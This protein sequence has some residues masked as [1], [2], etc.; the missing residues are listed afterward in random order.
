[1]TNLL[2][3]SDSKKFSAIAVLSFLGLLASGYLSLH[4]YQIRSGTAAFQSACNMGSNMNCDVVAASPFSE[5]FF[6][7][8]LS[9]FAAGWF[10]ALIGIALI[11]RNVFWSREA[12]RAAVVFTG[13]GLLLSAGYLVVMATVL[14]TYCLVCLIV[15]AINLALFGLALSLKPEGFSQHPLDRSK[16]KTFSVITGISLIIS[17]LGLRLL[18]PLEANDKIIDELASTMLQEPIVNVRSGAEFPSIGPATAPIT[19]VE[20]SDFQCPHC[21][22]G[23]LIMH[24]VMQRFPGKIRLVLRSFPLDPACNSKMQNGGHLFSCEA[25]RVA[26]CAHEQGRFA[27]VYETIFENQNSIKSGSAFAWAVALGLNA[28]KLRSCSESDPVKMMIQQDLTEAENLGVQSTPTYFLN[29]HKIQGASAA[30]VWVR[31]IET[32]LKEK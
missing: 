12:A 30:P 8:P 20:F 26:K 11:G 10:L 17:I 32:L 31:T 7:L 5:L 23:A 15:D 28:E 16:W 29:G 4:F 2:K 14:H 27:E 9:S 22:M 19:I 24:S 1:M 25:A 3:Q 13:F 6:G 18:N 21:K